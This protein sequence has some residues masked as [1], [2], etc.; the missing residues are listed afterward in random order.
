MGKGIKGCFYLKPDGGG[1]E[2]DASITNLMEER[3]KGMFL[4][5]T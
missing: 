2:R 1:R 3:G 4:S 5:Q